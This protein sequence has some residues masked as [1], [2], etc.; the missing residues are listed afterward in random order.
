[1]TK[2]MSYLKQPFFKYYFKNIYMNINI[3]I[4][5]TISEI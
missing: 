1:M 3:Y 4:F 2:L 5:E